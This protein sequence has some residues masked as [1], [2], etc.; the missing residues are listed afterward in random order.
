MPERTPAISALF[1]DHVIVKTGVPGAIGGQLFP[2]ELECVDRA[3][4]KRRDEFSAGRILARRALLQLGIPA[5]TILPHADRSPIWPAGIAGSITHTRSFCAVAIARCDLSPS[6]GLDVEEDSPL[7]TEL[8]E[9]ICTADEV[10]W[11]GKQS[12][13]LDERGRL[14]KLFFSAKEAFYKCQYP[15]T[16]RFLEFH[17]VELSVDL[18]SQTFTAQVRSE[19]DELPSGLQVVSNFLRLD[20]FVICASEAIDLAQIDRD[21]Y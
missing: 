18:V 3:I 12:S 2:E 8:T 11:I 19:V 15:L 9:R 6:L 14:G 17:D 10:A 20:G 5:T 4:K 1:R 16:G 21:L 7:K 13:S